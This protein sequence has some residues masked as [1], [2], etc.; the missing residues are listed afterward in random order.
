MVTLGIYLLIQEKKI[1]M[2]KSGSQKTKHRGGGE[3]LEARE[4]E[5]LPPFLISPSVFSLIL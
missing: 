4:C 3:V 1:Y 2:K 5:N